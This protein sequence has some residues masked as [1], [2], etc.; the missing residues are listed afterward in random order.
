[1]CWR[2]SPKSYLGL[3]KWMLIGAGQFLVY[4][5][6]ALGLFCIQSNKRAHFLDL[7]IKGLGKV[8]WFPPFEFKF[9]GA[10]SA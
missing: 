3:L 1:M 8:L 4:G 5:L 7:A 9:Y 10:A 6:I 2:K